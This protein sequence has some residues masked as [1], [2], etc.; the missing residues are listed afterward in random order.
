MN[1]IENVLVGKSFRTR[2][3]YLPVGR[4]AGGA[5]KDW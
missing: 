5:L 3:A 1:R 4:F 2:L